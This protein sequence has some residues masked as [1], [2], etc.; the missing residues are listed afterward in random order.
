MPPHRIARGHVALVPEGRRLFLNQ[1]VED[2]LILGA[3]HLRRDQAKVAEL[4]DEVF[5]LFPVLRALPRARRRRS[6][7]ASSRWSRSAA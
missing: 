5:E 4:L 3:L 2:N 6:A 7:A 1:T